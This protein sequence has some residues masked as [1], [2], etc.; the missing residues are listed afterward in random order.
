MN[1]GTDRHLVCIEPR[2][3]SIYSM[4]GR[5]ILDCDR[6]G[7]IGSPSHGLFFF[8][9]RILSRLR[10]FCNGKPP[11]LVC[12]SGVQQHSWMGYYLIANKS[13]TEA[14]MADAAKN[15]VEMRVS[16]FIGNGAHED[17]DFTNHSGKQ[18]RMRFVIEL[19]ADFADQA[20]KWRAV[21]CLKINRKW[22]SI[23]NKP[24][25][26]FSARAERHYV[27]QDESGTAKFHRAVSVIVSESDSL[28]RT[29]RP[30][31][32]VFDIHLSPKQSWHCCLDI[33]PWLDGQMYVPDYGCNAFHRTA[34]G[35]GATQ[36]RV[37]EKAA[38]IELDG[39]SAGSSAI[40]RTINMARADMVSLRLEDLDT[41]HGW[42]VAAGLPAYMG[43]FG[44]DSLTAAWQFAMMTP[45]LMYGS[46]ERIAELQ[47][48]KTVNW[49]DEQPGRQI[50]ESRTGTLAVLDYDIR[51]RSYCSVTTSGFYPV[52]LSELWHWTGDKEFARRMLNSAM[53]GLKYL[54][55]LAPHS[56]DQFYQYKTSSKAGV[57]NQGWKDSDDAIVGED[58]KIVLPPTA[59]CEEQGFVYC[60]K[61]LLSELLWWLDEKDAAKKVFHQ[62]QELKKRFN[63]KFWMPDKKFVALAIDSNDHQVKSIT[64]NPGHCLA[65]G[66]IDDAFANEVAHRLMAPD[67][68]SGWGIRTL[69]SENPAYNPFSYHCGSVWP[70]ENATFALGFVRYGLHQ[71]AQQ[72]CAA[73][74]DAAEIFAFNRLP[75]L[76]SGH[77]RDSAHPFP[78]LYPNANSPQ[79]WSSAA[80]LLMVQTL[81]QLYP[82]APLKTLFLDPHLPEWLPSLVVRNLQVGD[83]CISLK[84]DRH[85]DGKTGYSIIEQRGM[86]HVIRQPS[87]W[88][89]TAAPVERVVDLVGSA[90]H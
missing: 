37:L 65:T 26:T 9:S 90:F 83:A 1:G 34:G 29:T 10:Y 49:R 3:S 54:D 86:L 4:Q 41:E 59:T 47:G 53:D 76:F 30:R 61:L 33:C 17:L 57:I 32:I 46:L 35:T 11:V 44:R 64:S 66:I 42:V 27:N 15:A 24:A 20:A 85:A 28:P 8:E 63:D 25:L 81:L 68:F 52:I 31:Q 6:E 58:G 16:R 87:P 5:T 88:S 60:A 43:L 73:Q 50:H 18:V 67:L 12:C 80:V 7:I 23:Q 78:A 39:R 71:L 75:E 21:D 51:A 19:D 14:D 55:E 38:R 89:L 77:S 74:F 45:D 48:T 22:G 82:Y 56:R 84:F 13:Q 40:Q 36:Q 2:Y 79:A 70:V 69:S 62:A 72:L